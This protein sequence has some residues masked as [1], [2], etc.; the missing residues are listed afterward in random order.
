MLVFSL[1]VTGVH[2]TSHVDTYN[3]HVYFLLGYVDTKF[4]FPLTFGK[5]HRWYAYES[6]FYCPIG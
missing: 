2:T 4:L 6:P 3:W 1:I 5:L